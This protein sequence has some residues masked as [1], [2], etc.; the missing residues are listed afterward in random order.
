ML[1]REKCHF[2]GFPFKV[3]FSELEVRISTVLS[4]NKIQGKGFRALNF[5]W[6]SIVPIK[7]YHPK[8][9]KKQLYYM[10]PQPHMMETQ[11]YFMNS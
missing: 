6:K 8:C 4:K 2:I 5:F 10:Y 9:T 7:R 1:F 3:N 11:F